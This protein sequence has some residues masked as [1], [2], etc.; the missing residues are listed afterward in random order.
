MARVHSHLA[1]VDIAEQFELFLSIF[2]SI[3]KL[4]YAKR[5]WPVDGLHI[6]VMAVGEP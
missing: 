3:F 1:V 6:F 4:K 2:L 5:H